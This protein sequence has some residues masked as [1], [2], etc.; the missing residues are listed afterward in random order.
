MSAAGVIMSEA[1]KLLTLP[2]TLIAL[3]V[4]LVGSVSVTLLNTSYARAAIA[5]EVRFDGFDT[6]PIELAFAAAPVGVVGAVI[7][8][9][10]AFSSE[11]TANRADAGGGRQI[12]T[13]LVVAPGR[14]TVLAAKAITV[15]LVI[16]V[17]ALVTVSL[18]V[19]LAILVVGWEASSAND[20]DIVPRTLGVALY[21]VLSGLM[22][23]AITVVTRNGIAPL[24][25]LI[26]NS[27]VVSVSM[28]LTTVTS[29]AHWLPDLA[30]LRL[31]ARDNG[32]LVEGALDP[33]TGGLVMTAW[34]LGLLALSAIVFC[35]RDA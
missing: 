33:V 24:I 27:S 29:L 17:T 32:G 20:S 4:A 11:Y 25:I 15:A 7:I 1:R 30:G 3:G 13:T 18:T 12:A 10:V 2:A 5:G 34:A 35:R 19:T 14:L 21:W 23:L 26:M 8:G 6:S 31:F 9:V 22:A 16:G 28:L